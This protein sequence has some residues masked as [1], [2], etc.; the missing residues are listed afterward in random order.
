MRTGN[1]VG[2]VLICSVLASLPAF[3][4]NDKAV[5][6][7]V[8]KPD[9]TIHDNSGNFSVTVKVSPPLRAGDEHIVVLLD[10]K[11]AANGTVLDYNLSGIDRGRHK[12]QVRVMSRDGTALAV[13]SLEYVNIWRAS[14]LFRDRHK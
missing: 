8:P 5:R 7:L 6:I 3:A 12:L 10:G 14:R 9:A 2:W 4:G 11:E 1:F 13:S